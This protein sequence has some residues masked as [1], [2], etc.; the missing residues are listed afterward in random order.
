M[1][2]NECCSDIRHLS[3][4]AHK[5]SGDCGFNIFMQTVNPG[6]VCIAMES[7]LGTVYATHDLADCKSPHCKSPLGLM[8]A[9][10]LSGIKHSKLILTSERM[11]TIAMWTPKAVLD[12]IKAFNGNDGFSDLTLVEYLQKIGD[13]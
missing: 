13:I 11:S 4:E 7:T 12:A 1:F 2:C 9:I 6:W 5:S 8:A 10:E 3:I